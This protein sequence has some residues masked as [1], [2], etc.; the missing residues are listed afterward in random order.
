MTGFNRLRVCLFLLCAVAFSFV[1][2]SAFAR[3]ENDFIIVLD[4]SSSMAGQGGK[5][6]F[7]SVRASLNSYVDKIEEGDSLTFITFDSVVKLYPAVLI[8]DNNDRDIVKKYLSVVE[9]KGEWTYTLEMIRTVMKA[10][11]DLQA[12]DND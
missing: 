5:N 3:V 10:A 12:K 1:P 9:A 11:R 7:D 4:T 2:Y 6:I 8:E